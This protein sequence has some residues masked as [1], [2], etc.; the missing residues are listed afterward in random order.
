MFSDLLSSEKSAF[1][2][3]EYYTSHTNPLLS[4]EHTE[5]KILNVLDDFEVWFRFNKDADLV[6]IM[7][8]REYHWYTVL[9]YFRDHR[10]E[11]AMA[12]ASD[13]VGA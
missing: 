2:T 8:Q 5:N 4:F 3:I 7:R 9:N 1:R 13:I 10:Y 12:E 6:D 11:D